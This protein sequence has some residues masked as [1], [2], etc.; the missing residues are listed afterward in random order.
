MPY[1]EYECKGCGHHFE[2]MQTFEEHQRHEDHDSHQPLRC[3]KCGGKKLEQ[4]IAPVFVITS[5]KS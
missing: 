3:P 2:T 1:Y 4:V 5:K